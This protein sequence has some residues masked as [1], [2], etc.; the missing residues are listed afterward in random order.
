M[1]DTTAA[2]LNAILHETAP[3]PSSLSP[4]ITPALDDTVRRCLEKEESARVANGELLA[5]A[6]EAGALAVEPQSAALPPGGAGRTAVAVALF[7]NFTGDPSLDLVG[8]LAAD[9][10][11]DGLTQI[12]AADVAL[13]PSAALGAAGVTNPELRAKLRRPGT[14]RRSHRRPG[15]RVWRVLPRRR[16]SRVPRAARCA[17][18]QAPARDHRTGAG[19]TRAAIE[20]PRGVRRAVAGSLAFHLDT[21]FELRTGRP[22]SI[23][24]YREMTR[25]DGGSGTGIGTPSFVTS[26]AQSNSTQSMRA[27]ACTPPSHAS[28]VGTF[29]ARSRNRR[30]PGAGSRPHGVPETGNPLCPRAPGGPDVGVSG[31]RAPTDA[32]RPGARRFRRGAYDAAVMLYAVNHPAEASDLLA[33]LAVQQSAIRMGDTRDPLARASRGGP[34]R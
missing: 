23:E 11:T 19:G 3:P 34:L 29:C 16:R 13:P 33:A 30:H 15:G 26:N 31:G 8:L 5:L 25:A 9:W 32:P 10:V 22:P 14:T 28:S 2:T 4:G 21:R 20:S 17:D 1:R 12:S 27:R 7:E 24:A 18:G 6:L